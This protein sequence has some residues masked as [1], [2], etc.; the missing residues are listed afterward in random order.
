MARYTL[1]ADETAILTTWLFEPLGYLDQAF[2]TDGQTARQAL[3]ANAALDVAEWILTNTKHPDCLASDW[4]ECRI[5]WW[6]RT[7]DNININAN[8]LP[9]DVTSWRPI[10]QQ[11][12]D[13]I[14]EAFVRVP[15]ATRDQVSIVTLYNAASQVAGTVGSGTHLARQKSNV[16][17]VRGVTG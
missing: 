3:A 1:T 9:P 14:D 2:R 5:V 6:L 13:S 7:H 4:L 17:K 16:Q 10:L 8:Q 12:V 11:W 15:L